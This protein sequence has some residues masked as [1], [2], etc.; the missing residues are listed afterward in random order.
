MQ[1]NLTNQ[2]EVFKDNDSE[3]ASAVIKVV[4]N[5]KI[6]KD[7]FTHEIIT[8]I[9]D[10]F[11]ELILTK[12]SEISTTLDMLRTQLQEYQGYAKDFQDQIMKLDKDIAHFEKEI[13]LLKNKEVLTKKYRSFQL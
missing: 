2:I 12:N 7:N 11:K 13:N 4:T 10:Q 3:F 9:R 5:F 1:Q 6:N 8:G